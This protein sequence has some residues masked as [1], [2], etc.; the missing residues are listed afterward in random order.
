MT[1]TEVA[2]WGQNDDPVEATAIMPPDSPQGWPASTYTR[3]TVY[4]LDAKGRTTNVSTPSTA[5]YGSISTTE[6]EEESNDAIR[7]LSPDNRQTALE[8]GSAKSVE[9]ATLLSTVYTYASKCSKPGE[10]T[11]ERESTEFGTRLC[12]TEGPQHTIKYT[13]GK[14]QK[15][16][17]ARQQTRYFYDEHVPAGEP[18]AKETYNLLTEKAEFAEL[19]NR[20]QVEVRTTKTSYSGQEN[21]GWRLRAPT[22]VTEDP[23]GKK[24]THT[25]LYNSVTGQIVETRGPAGQNGGS[26]HDSK[27]IYYTS[28]ENKEGYLGCGLHPEWSGLVCETLPAKQPGTNGI[29]N[30]PITTTTYN[31]WNEPETVT[32][33]FPASEKVSEATRTKKETY[34]EAGRL[35]SSETTSTSGTDKSLPKVTD[36][37]STTTGLLEKQSTTIE[38]KTT[39]VT[40]KYSTLGQLVEYTDADGNTATYRYGGPAND[41]LIE[42]LT[43]GSN[44]GKAKQTYT[45]NTTTKQLEELTDSSAE[46]FTASYDAEGKLTSEIYPNGMCANTAYNSIGEA[47]HI[48]YIKTANCTESKPTVWFSETRNPSVRGETFTRTSTLANETYSYDTLGR[49]TETQETPASEGC[50]VRTYAYDEESNRLSLTKRTPGTEGKCATEGG[51]VENH[52]YDEANRMTDTGIEYDPLGNIV[53]LPAADAEGHELTSTFYVDGAVASQTQNGTTNEYKLDPVGRV[54][55]TK[56]GAT[57]ITT[58]YDAP[59]EAVAWTSES[60]EKWTRNI[61]GIDGTL[62]AIQTNGGTPILQLHDLQGNIIATAALSKE[63]TKLLSTYNSTEFG[64][65]NKEKTPPPYAWLGAGY[66]ASALSSG[67]ITYG[68]TSYVPQTGRPLQ[69]EQVEPPGAPGGTGVGAPYV[70]QAEPWVMQGAAREAAEALGLESGREREAQRE[71][72]EKAESESTI[73]PA[74]DPTGILWW[75]ASEERA[76]MFHKWAIDIEEALVGR[77]ADIGSGI[78]GM[79]YEDGQYEEQASKELLACARAVKKYKPKGVCWLTYEHKEF[80]WIGV[81]SFQL[82]LFPSFKVE[83]CTWSS[84]HVRRHEWF[85]CPNHGNY[86][87]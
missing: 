34:D 3:A 4:Y 84:G 21:L 46:K 82:L 15:E 26:A 61:P 86:A 31:M 49:L 56:T 83:E 50:S 63:A 35:T 44:S 62:Q 7:T 58:H 71:A 5:P 55:V 42:E 48:E 87:G 24:L 23:E 41:G 78:T 52:T 36:E 25:T 79:L 17:L 20:E 59:G 77:E 16:A 37:Y 60:V 72:Q 38:S 28:E 65:P 76:K 19:A 22:S 14:E 66:V 85:H 40:S 2:K 18:Y 43:D 12:E 8:A 29:S 69:S 39:I 11:E 30:L 1:T 73:G 47:T 54:R 51:T 80:D 32:E 75:K 10:P 70:S 13:A 81:A 45:Y 68:A 74:E 67:V 33:S 6:Y 57:E 9:V 53:K 27:I 64:V